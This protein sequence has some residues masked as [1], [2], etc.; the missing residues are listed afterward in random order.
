MVSH[1]ADHVAIFCSLSPQFFI[2]AHG[3]QLARETH[4]AFVMSKIGHVEQFFQ[5]FAAQ[6]PCGVRVATDG[7]LILVLF[8][9]VKDG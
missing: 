8:E 6:Y 9:F 2:N 5:S 4:D 1:D 7:E 3:T